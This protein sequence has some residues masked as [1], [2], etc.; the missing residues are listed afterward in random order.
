M[1][2]K[3][4][5]ICQWNSHWIEQPQNQS[6]CDSDY[7]QAWENLTV[8][9]CQ[10]SFSQSDTKGVTTTEGGPRFPVTEA[11]TIVRR[12]NNFSPHERKYDDEKGSE[13]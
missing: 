1:C 9:A 8:A 5:K 4:H 7:L 13:K 11:V 12:E 2:L 6:I 3:T 10:R